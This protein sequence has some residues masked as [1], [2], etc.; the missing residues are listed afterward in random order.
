MNMK[1]MKAEKYEKQ[2]VV[3]WSMSEKLNGVFARWTGR[4]LLSSNGNEYNAP[5]WFIDQLPSDIML[6]GE[7]YIDRGMLGKIVGTVRKKTPIDSEWRLIKF[8]VF[9]APDIKGGFETRLAFARK[10]LSGCSVAKTVD[11]EVC[12]SSRHL[13]QFY[14]NLVD[15]G[16]EGIMLHIPDSEYEYHQTH[17]LL[18]YKPVE[19][20]EAEVVGYKE[21]TGKYRGFREAMICRWN[22]IVFKLNGLNSEKFEFP[23]IGALVTFQFHGTSDIGKPLNASFLIERCY[24]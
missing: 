12:R 14:N 19:D 16:A 21:G 15:S 6:E 24:E 8:H 2:N 7:L 5:K 22:G 1:R 10:I 20:D 13:G 18:K 4:V 3:G 17:K 9:D 11:V 23:Q